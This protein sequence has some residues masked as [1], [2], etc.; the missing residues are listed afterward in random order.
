MKIH[1]HFF[2]ID[3]PNG[4]GKT[5]VIEELKLLTGNLQTEFI[6]TKEPTTSTLGM[7]IRENQDGY[8]SSSLAALV[9]AD[10]YHH[11]DTVIIPNLQQGRTVV[12]DRYLAS[13]LVYQLQDGVAAEFVL[14]LNSLIILPQLYF[15]L[16][17]NDEI[18]DARL[19]TR[20]GLTRFERNTQA[21]KETLLFA[22]AATR[23]ELL[24]VKV[25]SIDNTT[26]AAEETAK[27]I[28]K[29]ILKLENN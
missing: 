19:K 29:E 10:R 1:S 27:L 12:T 18:I 3:G 14:Q 5:S 11:L 16:T 24:G 21:E 22:G 17:G 25:I 9:A 23:L 4:I 28:L 13:S 2:A 7:F 26:R 20:N 15:I 6:F 8:H